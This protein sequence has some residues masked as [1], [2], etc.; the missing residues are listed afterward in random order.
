MTSL[1]IAA[2]TG[3]LAGVTWPLLAVVALRLVRVSLDVVLVVLAAV[4][5]L[6]EGRDQ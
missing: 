2:V 3:A 1:S 5:D 4:H 6:T